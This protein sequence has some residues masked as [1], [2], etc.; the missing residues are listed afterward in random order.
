MFRRKRQEAVIQE[1]AA[2][3]QGQ[4]AGQRIDERAEARQGQAVLRLD[5]EQDGIFP[6]DQPRQDDTETHDDAGLEAAAGA[7]F[8]EQQYVHGVDH[9]ERDQHPEGDVQD[10]APERIFHHS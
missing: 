5:I 7:R 4:P 8:A 10:D 9:G 2:A 3:E 1:L 6:E